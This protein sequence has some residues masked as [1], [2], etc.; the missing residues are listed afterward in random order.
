MARFAWLIVVCEYTYIATV[1]VTEKYLRLMSWWSNF[2][3]D[4]QMKLNQP[5]KLLQLQERRHCSICSF[6]H[7]PRHAD[8]QCPPS[9]VE[10][11][12]H[13]HGLQEFREMED[14]AT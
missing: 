6:Y 13:F 2:P 14:E 12:S 9:A 4:S 11:I 8:P 7:Q 1:T 3:Q 5:F 10:Q